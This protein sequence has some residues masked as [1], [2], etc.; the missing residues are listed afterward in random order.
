MRA[1]LI[2]GLEYIGRIRIFS[3]DMARWASSGDEQTS[4]NAPTRS[5]VNNQFNIN[6]NPMRSLQ[7]HYNGQLS[8]WSVMGDIHQGQMNHVFWRPDT[9]HRACGGWLTTLQ[10]TNWRCS[11]IMNNLAPPGLTIQH[12]DHKCEKWPLG[13]SLII[14]FQFWTIPRR[15]M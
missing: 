9:A 8:N 1:P 11:I 12:T 4:V 2:G 7:Q 13:E 10:I 5:P 6:L 15:Y 3:C 14:F